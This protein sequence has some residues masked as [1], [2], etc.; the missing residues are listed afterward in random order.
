MALQIQ[1]HEEFNT[2]F[3]CTWLV[4]NIWEKMA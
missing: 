1:A 4:T 3:Q 2:A